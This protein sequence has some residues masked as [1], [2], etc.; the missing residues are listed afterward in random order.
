MGVGLGLG[1][2]HLLL[3]LTVHPFVIKY[4]LHLVAE[5]AH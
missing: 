2:R 1:A 3:E 5:V 4:P